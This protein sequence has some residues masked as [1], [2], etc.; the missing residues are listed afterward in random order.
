LSE[1]K[2]KISEIE[3]FYKKWGYSISNSDFSALEKMSPER[4]KDLK[5]S[6]EKN[7]EFIS[8]AS[9]PSEA[10]AIKHGLM[11]KHRPLSIVQNDYTVQKKESK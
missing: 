9:K 7:Y 3:L 11:R 1:I 5:E 6:L 10:T 2:Q 8:A 4:L